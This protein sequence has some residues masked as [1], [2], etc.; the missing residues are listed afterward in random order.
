LAAIFY[1]P[2]LLPFQPSASDSYIF[3]YNNR[4]GIVILLLLVAIGAIWTKGLNLKFFPPGVSEPVPSRTLI[5][6]LVAALCGCLAMYVLAGRFGG[7]GES[8][9]EIDR[10]WMLSQGKIPYV[11]FE[12]PFGIALLYGPLLFSRLLSIG[13]VQA[14]Y[15]FWVIN[16]LLGILLLYAVVNLV[17]YPTKSKKAIFL[18]LYGSWFLAILNMGTHYTLLRYTCPLFFILLVHKLFRKAGAHSREYA[19]LLAVVF[20]IVLLLISPETAIACA[21]ACAFIFLLSGSSWKGKVPTTLIGFLLALCLVFGAALKLH[22][23]DTVKASG[24]GADSFPISFAPHFLLFFAAIFLCACYA[25]Q[26]FSKWRLYDN[27]FCLIAFSIPMIAAALG[28]SDSGHVILNGLGIFLASMF[29]VSNHPTAWKWCKGAFAVVFILVPV[30]GG[31]WLYLPSMMRCGLNIVGESDSNSPIRSVLSYLG[32]KVIADFANP[33]KRARWE[34]TLEN[35][36]HAVAPKRI[37]LPTAYP[38][39]HGTFLAPFGYRPNGFGTYL[40]N[41]VDYGYFEGVENANTLDAI[42]RKLSEIKDSPKEA[43]LLPDHFENNCHVDIRA[44]RL[45]I[46][47]LFAFP[48]FGKAA[49]TESVRQPICDFIFAQYRL[50]QAPSPQNFGYG[51][52]IAKSGGKT[53]LTK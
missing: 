20:T 11:D 46:S 25:F 5:I 2:S 30:V 16:C 3:G 12:W 17:D 13:I 39:W 47:I 26:R 32:R 28:R 6:T 14:Y 45:E 52:W 42:R 44:E 4:A 7:F 48:Y 8:S 34:K 41:Q 31:T 24:G 33:T 22:V 43:L 36:Q 9:Y 19:A 35:A 38:D 37:D 10:A 40:S 29:Y 27:T 1:L 21:F 49:H 23:L 15:F 53:T 51:L 18:F 50:Q